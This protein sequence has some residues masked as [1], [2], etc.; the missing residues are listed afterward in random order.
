MHERLKR[1]MGYFRYFDLMFTTCTIH[2]WYPILEESGNKEV[3]TR[4]FQFLVNNKGVIVYGFVIM[5]NHIHLIWSNH[6]SYSWSSIFHSLKSYTS[7]KLINSIGINAKFN[8]EYFRV[9]KSN[10]VYQIWKVKSYNIEIY[11]PKT[12]RQKLRYIHENPIRSNLANSPGDYK[13]SSAKSYDLGKK[14]WP[15]LTLHY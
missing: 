14:L 12:Y 8:S 11:S 9:D 4:A 6:G 5:P 1:K 13:F 7:K 15:F 2:K 10:K 3:I